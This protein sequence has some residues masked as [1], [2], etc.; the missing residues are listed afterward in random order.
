MQLIRRLDQSPNSGSIP[1]SA[2]RGP[3]TGITLSK[4]DQAGGLDDLI[5]A[6]RTGKAFGGGN[7][8]G[9]R[10]RRE[11]AGG[12]KNNENNKPPPPPPIDSVSSLKSE[13]KASDKPTDKSSDKTIGQRKRLSI[14]NSNF[15]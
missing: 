11:R 5:S 15:L 12:N 14:N 6:I 4:E 10:Q 1:A 9:P 7:P 2:D 8:D 3:P 13:D